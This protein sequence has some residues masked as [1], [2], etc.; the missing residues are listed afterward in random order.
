MEKGYLRSTDTGGYCLWVLE[1][2]GMNGSLDT[3]GEQK[4]QV[5]LHSSLLSLFLLLCTLLLESH[6]F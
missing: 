6:Y 4:M 5:T 1:I 3:D 2:L